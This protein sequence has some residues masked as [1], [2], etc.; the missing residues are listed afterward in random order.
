[1]ARRFIFLFSV[2]WIMFGVTSYSAN[3]SNGLLVEAESFQDKGGWKVDQKFMDILGSPY[4]LAHGLG[5]PVA[6]AKT[7]VT[8]PAAGVYHIWVRTKNWAPGDWEAPGR[9]KIILNGTALKTTF[10]TEAGWEWQNGGSI[11]IPSQNAAIE[12]QDLTG[13]DGR[14]DAIF[15]T[16]DRS[17]TPPDNPKEMKKWRNKLSGSGEEPQ[18]KQDFDV[19]IVGGGI[20][21]CAASLAAAQQGLNVALINDRPVLGGNAGGEIRVHTLGITGKGQALLEK[22]NTAHWPNGSPDAL[23]DDIKRHS[24]LDA[25]KNITQFLGWRAYAVITNENTI[26]SIDAQHIENGRTRRFVAPVFIDCTGDGWIGYWAGAEYRCGRE[27]RDEFGEQWEEYG[28]LW[29][30][31]KPDNRVMGSSLLWYSRKTDTKTVFPDVPWATAVA[32]DLEGLQGEWDWEYSDDSLNQVYDAEAIRD[33]LLRAIYGVFSNAKKDPK[34]AGASL[35]WVGYILGKRESRRL[36]GDYIYT[37]SDMVENRVFPDTVAE[38]TRAIDVHYQRILKDSKYDFLSEAIFRNTGKYYI[39]FR[40]LYSKNIKNLMMAGRCFSCSHIGLGGPRV[41]N[42]TGQ[43][44]IAAGYAASL[45]KKY[46]T[47]PRGIYENH[48]AKLRRLIGYE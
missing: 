37:M 5:I 18:A 1:M 14:C 19:V 42:T 3:P 44:G 10:G 9:F 39:P 12:L 33:H 40:C 24:A 45:C 21:G 26:T 22:I 41:M 16:I 8:F 13:F 17:F 23:K 11:E 34:N 7:T 36:M 47:N 38:E 43:M 6:N 35:E 25:E 28:W 4:L 27:S 46:N 20:A 15:F 48:I 2:F 30:P 29:S 32:K 31:E